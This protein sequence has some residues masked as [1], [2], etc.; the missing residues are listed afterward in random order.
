MLD[1]REKGK[2]TAEVLGQNIDAELDE[3]RAICFGSFRLLRGQRLLLEGDKPLRLGSRALEIL[4]TLVERPY[5]LV[6]K[7]EL[8]ARVWPNIFVEPANLTVHISALRRVLGDGRNGN[9][10]FINIPG[11][12]YCFVAPIKMSKEFES[13]PP[14]PGVVE[15]TLNLSANVNRSIDRA[16][17]SAGTIVHLRNDH[18]LTIDR[19]QGAGQILAMLSRERIACEMRGML[20]ATPG[21]IELEFAN[22]A[23]MRI[24]GRIDTQ[25]VDVIVAALAN[26]GIDVVP[27]QLPLNGK[28]APQAMAT[29]IKIA[30]AR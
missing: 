27:V 2:K 21:A 15:H 20:P 16:D 6:S 10:F 3:S 19:P 11:R 29:L 4:I 5:Q 18:Q 1:K 23:Q 26:A 24:T 12:G 13:Y 17:M 22:G 14:R 8:I 7:E 28:S 9:R 30:V 25:V